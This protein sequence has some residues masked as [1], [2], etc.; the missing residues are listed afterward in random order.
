MMPSRF[1]LGLGLV[2]AWTTG[3]TAARSTSAKDDMAFPHA[4]HARLFTSCATCH[5][6]IERGDAAAG[7]P[8]PAVCASCHNGTDAK[9]VRWSGA[10]RRPSNL[11]FDHLRHTRVSDAAGDRL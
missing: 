4:R 3:F 6:G 11:R 10:T 2:A 8:A 5:G 9:V 1:V 7:F